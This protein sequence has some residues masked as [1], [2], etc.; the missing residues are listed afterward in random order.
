MPG[1]G[2]TRPLGTGHAKF[3]VLVALPRPPLPVMPSLWSH[4]DPWCRI[5]Q[6]Y[7]MQS[8]QVCVTSSPWSCPAPSRGLHQALG[9]GSHQTFGHAKPLGASHTKLLCAG[10]MKL[11]D[12]GCTKPLCAPCGSRQALV[13]PTSLHHL[14]PVTPSLGAPALWHCLGPVT[15]IPPVPLWPHHANSSV[16]ALSRD[17]HCTVPSPSFQ[18]YGVLSGLTRT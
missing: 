15:S 4:Q 6:A 11:L 1:P 17:P 8:L 5:H 10:H 3:Q 14:S 7:V 9:H 13:T 12:T 16:P 2:H 18:S